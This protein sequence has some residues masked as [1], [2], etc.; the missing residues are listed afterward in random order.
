MGFRVLSKIGGQDTPPAAFVAAWRDF[1]R[2]RQ[3]A[4]HLS[5]LRR[6]V[7]SNDANRR[8]LAFAILLPIAENDRARGNSRVEAR[9][10]IE[11]AWKDPRQS[12]SLLRA[13]GRMDALAYALHVRSRM[14]DRNPEVRAAAG[15]A[16][17]LLGLDEDHSPNRGPKIASLPYESVVSTAVKEK[18]DTRRGE[19]LF[20]RQG[21]VA[22]HAV[23]AGEPARGPSLLGI[24][25]RYSRADLAESILRPSAKIAQGFEPQ[26]FATADGRTFAGFVVRESGDEVE[27]SDAQGTATIL[28]KKEIDE[29]AR[30]TVSIMPVGLVDSLTPSD[31]ASL[32]AYLESL[33]AH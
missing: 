4:R 14:A 28:S 22:C 29:R 27:I 23:A 2:D 30:G 15:F 18:G 20:Q 6:E 26:S 17:G 1:V 21:C 25:T 32:L 10:L 33:K 31:L 9:N 13:I 24:S 5:D 19:R 16:S 7:K 12:A 11:S 8:E 3:Q